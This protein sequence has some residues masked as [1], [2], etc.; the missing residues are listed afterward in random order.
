MQSKDM[1]LG[2]VAIVFGTWMLYVAGQL[3][4]GAAFWPKIVASGIIVLGIIIFIYGGLA[5]KKAR[6]QSNH[7]KEKAKPQYIN[8]ISVTILLM[9]YYFSFQYFSYIISTFFLIS[10]TSMILG[11]RNWKVMIPTSLIVSV[12]LYFVFVKLFGINFPGVFF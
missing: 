6:S 12:F 5:Y 9:I 3:K 2:A 11:Y 4:A 8:V 7:K 1:G 10:M